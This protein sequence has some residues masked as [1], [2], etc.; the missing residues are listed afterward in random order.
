MILYVQIFVTTATESI[1]KQSIY[2]LMLDCTHV[3]VKT[4][5]TVFRES[6]LKKLGL[7]HTRDKI[8]KIS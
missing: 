3:R 7:Q 1:I 2:Y 6:W 8:G 4:D 5:V